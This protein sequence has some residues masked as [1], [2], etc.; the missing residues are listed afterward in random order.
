[1][2]DVIITRWNVRGINNQSAKDNVRRLILESKDNVRRLI[3]ESK[4]NVI[5]LHET[6]CPNWSDSVM[7]GILVSKNYGWHVVNPSGASEG[8]LTAWNNQDLSFQCVGRF[9]NCIWSKGENISGLSFRLINVYGPYDLS[10]KEVF[11]R[12]LGDI[13]SAMDWNPLYIMEDFNSIRIKEDWA[14]KKTEQAV[15]ITRT[16]MIPLGLIHF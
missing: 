4:A 8:L 11:W 2:V 15:I 9:N 3:R 10:E 7:E 5:L 16:R 6:K 12:N 13:V 14:L 1:M